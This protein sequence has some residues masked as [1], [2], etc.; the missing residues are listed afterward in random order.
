[1]SWFRP[2]P[3]GRDDC[4]RHRRETRNYPTREREGSRNRSGVEE[5]G[6]QNKAARRLDGHEEPGTSRRKQNGEAQGRSPTP[7]LV[8]DLTDYFVS[9][10]VVGGSSDRMRDSACCHTPASHSIWVWVFTKTRSY[11]GYP[12]QL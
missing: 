5:V 6:V 4:A 2:S 7:T 1:M 3:F 11:K 10:L 12:S 8:T 9:L